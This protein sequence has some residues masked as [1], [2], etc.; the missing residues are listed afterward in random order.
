MKLCMINLFFLMRDDHNKAICVDQAVIMIITTT[1]TLVFQLIMNDA[2]ISL[3]RF[4]S[5]TELREEKESK[6]REMKASNHLLR[7][8]FN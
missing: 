6:Y 4:M 2:I 3:L 1:M 8:C 5:R 7:K